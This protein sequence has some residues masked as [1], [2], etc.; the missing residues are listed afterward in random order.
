M[1]CNQHLD[2]RR[3]RGQ[4]VDQLLEH[5]ISLLTRSG[6]VTGGKIGDR[7]KVPC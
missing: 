3:R 4:E 2:T 7:A 1:M 5:V 6:N